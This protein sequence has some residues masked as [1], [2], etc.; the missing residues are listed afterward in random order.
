[1][2]YKQELITT[3]HDFGCNLEFLESRATQLSEQ[4]PTAVL[5]PALYEELERP[6]LAHIRNHLR[7]CHFVKTVILSV[8][9][10]SLEQYA[11]AVEFFRSLPQKT[12]IIWENGPRIQG[13]LERL[14]DRGLD[15]ARFKGKGKAVWLGLGVASL[16]ADA[17]ALHDADIVTYDRSYPLK[18]LFPLLEKEC[19]IAFNKAYYARLSSDRRSLNGRVARLFVTPLLTA[20]IEIFGYQNYLRYL[21]SYRYPLS[22]EFA[23]TGDLALTT[24]IPGN[25][26]LE[27]GML[28]EVYRNVAEKRISQVDLGIFDHKHQS[29]GQSSQEGLQKM[30]RDILQSV[31]RTLTETE[32]VIIS[33]DHIRA[34]RVKFRREAQDYTRQ[35]FVDA[36]FNN[37]P[38]DRHEEEN[39]VEVFDKLILE[40]GEEYFLNPAGAQIPDWTRAIAVMPELREE[41]RAATIADS[42]DAMAYTH[43]SESLLE[44]MLSVSPLD[45]LQSS[46]NS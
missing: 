11:K 31:L 29:L 15:I 28:A 24:R 9:A 6:A 27:I 14:R 33:M 37:L 2:D 30:C 13:I 12:L 22:G 25:W 3:I 18:L 20:L 39:I 21:S 44:P 16:E 4:F 40:A 46:A 10:D 42:Q 5:I 17:I 38:Y 43:P 1:M 35:Y 41:L 7:E 26:G 8:Y 23:L 32:R 19:G 45:P 34:L 36:L